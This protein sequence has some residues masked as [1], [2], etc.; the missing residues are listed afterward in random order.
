MIAFNDQAFQTEMIKLNGKTKKKLS[1]LWKRENFRENRER[2]KIE[3]KERKKERKSKVGGIYL[4]SS[5][6]ERNQIVKKGN[7]NNRQNVR[8]SLHFVSWSNWN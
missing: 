1:L 2:K 5:E 6:K 4:G 8:I 3:S 7:I